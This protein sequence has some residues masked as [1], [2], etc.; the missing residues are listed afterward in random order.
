MELNHHQLLG[1]ILVGPTSN[2]QA[3]ASP[4]QVMRWSGGHFDCKGVEL[5]W[6]PWSCPSVEVIEACEGHGIHNPL[7]INRLFPFNLL[8]CAV[9]DEHI[10]HV[11]SDHCLELFWDVRHK[12]LFIIRQWRFN[13]LLIWFKST[14]LVELIPEPFDWTLALA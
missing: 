1:D 2:C 4:S 11:I 6:I 5:I 3:L 7:E 13:L 10:R 9:V 14:D 12:A 8:V